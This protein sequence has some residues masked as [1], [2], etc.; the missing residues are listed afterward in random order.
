MVRLTEVTEENWLDV[1][2]LSVRDDQKGFLAPALGILARGYVY[3][4]CRA[5][6]FAIE[7]DGTV[8]GAALVRD[9]TEEPLGYDLQQF[10][11]DARYQ[12][13]GYGSEALGLI[14]DQLRADGKFDRVEVC[15][16][17]ED[18]AAIH[19]YEKHGFRDSGYTDPDLPDSVCMV[20]SLS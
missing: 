16:K 15:V 5:R 10:M 14:L 7:S 17:R 12:G 4:D 2:S 18:A 19:L 13:K 6:V 11:I 8:V 1:A 3:R 9:F 20:C